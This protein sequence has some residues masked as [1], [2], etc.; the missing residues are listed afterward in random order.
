MHT[1]TSITSRNSLR[2]A[3]IKN[4]I[5]IALISLPLLAFTMDSAYADA[6]VNQ[7]LST[8]ITQ[9]NK[10]EKASSVQ[11]A[12][13]YLHTVINCL[14]G[15]NGAGY[16]KTAGDPCNGQG[17]G[18]MKDYQNEGTVDMQYLKQ[19]LEDAQ[20]GLLTSRVKIAQSA[21]NMASGNLQSAREQL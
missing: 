9:A 19:A 17:N 21:A 16:D 8:A 5:L 20:Y 12:D 7:E 11:Q 2:R 14:V 10:A 3:T 18:A 15:T 4:R 13:Q 1:C 6:S